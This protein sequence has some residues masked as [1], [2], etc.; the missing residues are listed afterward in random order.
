[1]SECK[2]WTS[3]P[4]P[5]SKGNHNIYRDGKFMFLFLGDM[6][7]VGDRVLDTLNKVE[8]SHFSDIRAEKKREDARMLAADIRG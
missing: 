1:M 3:R 5:F 4:S 7:P 8:A 2:V 6:T